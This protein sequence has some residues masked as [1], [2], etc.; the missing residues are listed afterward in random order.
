MSYDFSGRNKNQF[1][2]R[3]GADW[4]KLAVELEIPAHD[5]RRFAQG[6][7]GYDILDWLINQNKLDGLPDA[8][9]NIGRRDL[10]EIFE[11]DPQVMRDPSKWTPQDTYVREILNGKYLTT[12]EI[13]RVVNEAGIPQ[14]QVHFDAGPSIDVWHDVVKKAKL[15][16]KVEKLID[17][18]IKDFPD[19]PMLERLKAGQFT[20][21]VPDRPKEG[22]DWQPTDNVENLEKIMGEQ[23]TLLPISF[24]EVGLQKSR[25]VCLVVR[26][27]GLT[28]SGF[29]TQ[30][31]LLI[32]NHH[33]LETADQA[34]KAKIHF[35][36]QK[37]ATGLDRPAAIYELAPQGTGFATSKPHDWSI[38]KVAG[39]A[40]A[41]W[42]AIPVAEKKVK[43]NDRVI[44]IQHPGG[45][46]KAI[47]LYHNL[48]TYADDNRIQYLTDTNPGSSGSP[49]FDSQWDLIAIHHSGG[50]LREPGSKQ[51]LFRNEGIPIKQLL[52]GAQEL[53]VAE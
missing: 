18:A 10:K 6:D 41:H 25:S 11:Q 23:S 49:V 9:E 50:W 5:Q 17:V 32:T 53:L 20:S 7:E 21:V 12:Q 8:C 22:L 1:A 43:K 51:E 34:K 26:E 14:N 24:L 36:V 2:S 45:G 47:A 31:N 44:I 15:H 35:N 39:D 40:N 4:K 16:G 52:T 27:D 28:G 38:V 33:V 48:V 30:S 42:G 13:T 46:P 3:L 19:D 37:T 29:L